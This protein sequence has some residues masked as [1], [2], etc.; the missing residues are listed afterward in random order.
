MFQA[1]KKIIRL[2]L[3]DLGPVCVPGTKMA[4]PGLT[5]PEP[6]LKALGRAIWVRGVDVEIMLSNPGSIPGG[7]TPLDANYGNG[8]SCVD[9]AAE[10]IKT[11]K[12]QFPD[13]SDQDLRSKVAEN[14]RVCFIRQGR[15]TKWRDGASLGMHAKH[16]IVDDIATYIGSQNLYVC[17]LAEWG[18]LIDDPGAT[19]KIVEEY[20]APMWKHSF[21]GEDCDVQ[22]VMDGLKISRESVDEADMSASMKAKIQQAEATSYGHGANDM[23]WYDH[24]SFRR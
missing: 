6:Y 24:E 4:L 22:G 23:D 11:I 9:V 15:G 20:W 5:W 2:A 13:A 12:K 21:T 8:W 1:S 19:E 14:L 18:V 7:L 3:Q 16:F 17:D 10:I